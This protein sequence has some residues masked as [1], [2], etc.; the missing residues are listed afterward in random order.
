MAAPHSVLIMSASAGTGHLRAAEAIEKICRQ[1]PQIDQVVNIDALTYTNKLFRRFYSNLY[2]QLIKSAPTF[3]GWF[4]EN[5]DEPWR[6][7]RMRLML[8]RMNT[9]PLVR[10]IRNLNPDITI[11]THFL[12]AEIM[13]YLIKKERLDA[14]LSITVT[15]FDVHAM[16]LSRVFH[17][18]F[19]AIEEAKVHLTMMGLPENRITVSGIPIDPVF[20]EHHDK[21]LLRAKHGIDGTRPVVLVSAGALGVGSAEYVVRVLG[22]MKTPAQIVVICGSNARLEEET[23]AR[24]EAIKAPHLTFRVLGFT[25]EMNEWMAVANL[26]I[27]KPGGLTTAEA[28]ASG[29]PMLIFQPIPGQEWRNSDHLLENGIAVKCNLITTMA[30]KVDLLLKDPERL[31]AM[32]AAARKFG[33][34]D[35]ARTVVQ[36]LI[37]QFDDA[38]VRVAPGKQKRMTEAARTS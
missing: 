11:C 29:L 33:H 25:H 14:R 8:N 19:V 23:R 3:L 22:Y 26:F 15:D 21:D 24:V 10:L 12:P 28:L 37:D 1:H 30:Y 2:I 7:D 34:A 17:H 6:T 18:Y 16:W 27:G 31:H 5:T 38:A 13:S 4:Y 20:N 36:T 9:R 35:A 32:S